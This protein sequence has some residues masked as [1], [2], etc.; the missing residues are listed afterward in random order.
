MKK[1]VT[2]LES[3]VSRI[4]DDKINEK[5]SEYEDKGFELD[6]I[7]VNDVNQSIQDTVDFHQTVTLVFKEASGD[8]K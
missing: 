3:W 8:E 7:K 2:N 1:R 5:I 4:E 6:E